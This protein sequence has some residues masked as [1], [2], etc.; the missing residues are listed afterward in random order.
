[1]RSL[2]ARQTED[3]PKQP[4][5]VDDTNERLCVHC[6]VD[7]PKNEVTKDH[8]FPSSWYTDDTPPEV[9]RWT[10]PSCKACN[11]K[12]GVL[13]K[14]LFI[15]LALCID[16]RKAEASGITKKLLRTLG[17]GPDMPEKERE[18]R[19]KLRLEVLAATKPYTGDETLPT[20]PGLGLHQGFSPESQRAVPIRADCLDAVLEKVF[21]GCE[22]VLNNRQYVKLPRSIGIYHVHQ[23]PSQV[24]QTFSKFATRTSLG[25]G[26][27]IKRAATQD[28][29]YAVLYKAIIWGTL[30][31]YA[32]IDMYF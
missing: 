30:V 10:V 17:V 22:Y 31:S 24:A 1:M 14:E 15:R 29:E 25:P 7:L 21:R 13:E 8:V 5:K 26:F 4:M 27:E 19:E 12:F 32:S 18:I 6:L 23:E 3:S 20:L 9:Q 28:G 2:Q 16:P 11:G